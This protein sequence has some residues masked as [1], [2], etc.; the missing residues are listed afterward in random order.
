MPVSER[1]KYTEDEEKQL[2]S[3][4]IRNLRNG[5]LFNKSACDDFWY[6]FKSEHNW[7]RSVESIDSQKTSLKTIHLMSFLTVQEMFHLMSLHKYRLDKS[8]W[9]KLEERTGC[10][11]HVDSKLQFRFAEL[12]GKRVVFLASKLDP[13]DVNPIVDLEV[14]ETEEQEL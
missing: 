9:Q 6:K 2:M 11:I 7:S 3:Y 10:K 1:L 4:Y 8:E 14:S 13:K 12:D 5:H